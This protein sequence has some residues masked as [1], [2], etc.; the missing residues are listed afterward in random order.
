MVLTS[1]TVNVAKQLL[2]KVDVTSRFTS[3]KSTYVYHTL[4]KFLDVYM[5]ICACKLWKYVCVYNCIGV[6]M[7][8]G[9][10]TCLHVFM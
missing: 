10:Y 2:L 7:C 5:Q 6:Y 1:L 3:Y 4:C 9:P 8:V